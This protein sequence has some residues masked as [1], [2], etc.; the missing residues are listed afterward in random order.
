MDRVLAKI[1]GS[2]IGCPSVTAPGAGAVGLSKEKVEPGAGGSSSIS[3]LAFIL[4]FLVVILQPPWFAEAASAAHLP[5]YAQ[6]LNRRHGRARKKRPSTFVVFFTS[7]I[8]RHLNKGSP[9]ERH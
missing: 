9:I 6:N 7:S 3:S 1:V 5:F 4:P 8:E 2:G